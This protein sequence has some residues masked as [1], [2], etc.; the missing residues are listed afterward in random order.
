MTPNTTTTTTITIDAAL[1]TLLVFCYLPKWQAARK[2][3]AR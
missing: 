3:G 2:G 1:I